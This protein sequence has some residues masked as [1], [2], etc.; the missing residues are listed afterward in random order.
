MEVSGQLYAAAALLPGKYVR[1]INWIG[2]FADPRAGLDAV[3]KKKN[4]CPCYPDL[5]KA[6]VHP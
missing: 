4:L 1:G 3:T 6:I 2:G 5:G